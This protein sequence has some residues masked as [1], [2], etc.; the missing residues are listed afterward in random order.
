MC[1]CDVLL[2]K[3]FRKCLFLLASSDYKLFTDLKKTHVQPLCHGPDMTLKGLTSSSRR[4]PPALEPESAASC[5]VPPCAT[6]C[7][8]CPSLCVACTFLLGA[9][10][11]WLPPWSTGPAMSPGKVPETRLRDPAGRPT[12]CA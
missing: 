7:P 12:R 5:R 11:S 4:A 10:L 2:L 9:L 6:L 8:S 3:L 1:A